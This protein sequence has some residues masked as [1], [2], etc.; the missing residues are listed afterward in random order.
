MGAGT[1][2]PQNRI[3]EIYFGGTHSQ[4]QVGGAPHDLRS[5]PHKPKIYPKNN[6]I[7]WDN[8]PNA[9]KKSIPARQNRGFDFWIKNN[10]KFVLVKNT[11]WGA[12]NRLCKKHTKIYFHKRPYVRKRFSRLPN[13]E[14]RNRDKILQKMVFFFVCILSS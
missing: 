11:S 3:I 1:K 10:E 2:V 13:P 14:R 9:P 8:C 12:G 7:L 4:V 5:R 6:T